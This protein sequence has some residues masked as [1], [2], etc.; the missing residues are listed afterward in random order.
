MARV[1]E[2]I[3]FAWAN[4]T[5]QQPA[6][7]NPYDSGVTNHD[8]LILPAG[9]TVV[10]LNVSDGYAGG[11]SIAQYQ[12]QTHTM[13]EGTRQMRRVRYGPTRQVCTN[14]QN[15]RNGQHSAVGSVFEA[16]GSTWQVLE[17]WGE[18]S[19]HWWMRVQQ[20]WVDTWT[21]AYT[22]WDTTDHVIDGAQIAQTVLNAQNGWLAGI[23]LYFDS[24]GSTG[25][26]YLHLCETD[27]GLP[28]PTKCVG[29]TSVAQADINAYPQATPF[30]FNQPVFLEAGKR[31]AIVITT[32]GDHDLAVVEGTEY[33]NGTLF[34][35]T[36]GAYHQGDFT[37]DLM[38]R[39]KFIK[40]NNPR[41]T[42]E[43]TTLSLSDGIA[44]LDFLLEA[45]V[46][47]NTDLI[48]EYQKEG[49]GTWYPVVAETAEQLL[50]LPAMLHMRAVFDGSQDMMPGLY[51]PGSV[52]R[53]SRPRTDFKHISVNRVLAA[54]SENIDIILQLENWDDS[55][56]T[57]TVKLI[58][59]EDTYTHDS[60]TDTVLAGADLP[61]IKRT[62]NFLPLPSTGISE[63]QVQIEGATTNALEIFHVAS[64]M[65]VAK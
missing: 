65:Y 42:V 25:V 58:N 1:D 61:T 11:L 32:Q 28:D 56:H 7:F 53:A 64:G 14:S 24:I 5:E 38:M 62:V 27:L 39:W 13:K 43:L 26:V 59:G 23:D 37:Q 10:R 6:L 15:W 36:D 47:E 30:R 2:G 49:A 55:K 52:L 60:V 63:F 12:Y 57:C 18:H 34:Q 9:E 40:F 44:D 20:I 19:G 29:K 45:V 8:G 31:Y 21:E 4:Q 17:R 22:Y 3:R 48:F 35:S 46:P 54:A 50:G 41:T 51:L 33:T 16:G